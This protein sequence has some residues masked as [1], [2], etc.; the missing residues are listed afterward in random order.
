MLNKTRKLMNEGALS[1]TPDEGLGTGREK[2][3]PGVS[4]GTEQVGAKEEGEIE[5][6]VEDEFFD[7]EDGELSS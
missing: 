2:P 3:A 7:V 4:I 6:K 5:S 1:K